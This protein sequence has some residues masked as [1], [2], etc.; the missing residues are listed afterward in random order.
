VRLK[1]FGDL[2]H[3]RVARLVFTEPDE[4]AATDEIESPSRAFN[5][6][7]DVHWRNINSRPPPERGIVSCPV[8]MNASA[9]E[10]LTQAV[11]ITALELSTLEKR[12]TP[13]IGPI[14]YRA[15]C[16]DG[17]R[18]EFS[19][20]QE[21]VE[22]D[23]APRR[24]ITVLLMSARSEDFRTVFSLL[25]QSET[26]RSIQWNVEG[27]ESAVVATKDAL[28]SF[29]SSVRAPYF[30]LARFD[31]FLAF[32][33]VFP[34]AFLI[35]AL[36]GLP[37]LIRNPDLMR[38]ATPWGLISGFFLGMLPALVGVFL[39][40]L[41]NR[42]FPMASFCLGQGIKR[43]EAKTFLRTAVVLGVLVSIV[44]SVIGAALL[45]R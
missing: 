33:I 11:V 2:R 43:H 34:V 24:A 21:L 39:N 9:S 12:L 38:K 15:L 1:S 20:L 40:Q 27:S 44:G 18:R 36:P 29:F 35:W 5:R 22:F 42:V 23:N 32:S 30:F 7:R 41:R 31:Y 16:S 10:S 17:I 3:G 19:S 14:K 8:D 25:I 13:L 4:T 26:S 45:A 6:V 37:S 28:E